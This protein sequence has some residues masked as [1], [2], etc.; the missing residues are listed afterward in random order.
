VLTFHPH[1][2][3]VLGKRNSPFYL[4]TPEERAERMGE[5]GVD[6]VITHP[7][8]QQVANTSARDFIAQLYAHLHINCLCVGHD[9]ALGK[10]REGDVPTLRRLGEEFGYQVHIVEPVEVD[11]KVVSSSL[12]RAALADGDVEM[13]A[14]LLGRPYEIS[15]EVVHGDSRGRSIGIPTANLA[16]RADRA[17]PKPGVYTCQA[18]L[19]GARFGAVTNV[20]YRPTFNDQA[21]APTVEA[22]L[23]DFDGEIYGAFLCLAFITRLRDE[24][25][26]ENVQALVEQIRRDIQRG[27]QILN[28]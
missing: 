28:A 21:P 26:F 18:T 12:I 16:V 2:A 24:K 13:A 9:F 14:R 3:V 19:Q 25:R 4:T 20:G 6:V 27:R 5:L 15:G 1:P 17:L 8:T 11:G 22:H 10:G 7:F 23:L